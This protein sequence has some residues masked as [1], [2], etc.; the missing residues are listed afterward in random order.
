MSAQEFL[1]EGL[2]WRVGNGAS[3]R[4]W[5]DRWLPT[6][7]ATYVESAPMG[8]P[9]DATVREL[10]SPDTDEWDEAVLEGC[11]PTEIANVIRQIPLRNIEEND[12]LIWKGNS[13]GNYTVR[14][15][16]RLWMK[17]FKARE[18][19][20][21]IGETQVWKSL[22][23]LN[24]PPKVKHFLWRFIRDILPT[25]DHI[26]LKSNRWGDKCPF[27]NIRETQAH[28]FGEC[29]WSARLWRG[30]E[31]AECFELRQSECCYSWFKTVLENKQS[32]AVEEWGSLLWFIWKERNAQIFNGL[33]LREDEIV[34][35]AKAFIDEYREQQVIDRGVAAPVTTTGWEKP[36]QGFVKVNTD[37]GVFVDGGI[38]LGVVVR[39]EEGNFILAAAKKIA[40]RWEPEM[41][42]ALAAEFGVQVAVE[43][44]LQN[45]ILETDCQ[46]LTAKLAMAENIH[47][48]IGIVCRNILKMLRETGH[49]SWRYWSREGNKAAHIMSHSETRWNESM[50]WL[51][52]PPI[53]LVDQI[54]LD[55]VTAMP[56]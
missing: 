5:G 16:Y 2:R 19:I 6:E 3:I 18:A 52:R 25:G 49:S 22:W 43:A 39:G 27:C 21:Q 29:A 15:G 8:L 42:E 32:A 53:F 55:N 54:L 37:A 56:A 12:R 13:S 1:N 23:N 35:R 51:D 36:G 11:F 28:I 33:K 47:T 31:L 14:D 30:T 24:I 46:T 34:P 4:V 48:E 17:D 9:V 50:V 45:L 44:R 41:A 7:N 40:G 10:I 20:V 26:S 38:G